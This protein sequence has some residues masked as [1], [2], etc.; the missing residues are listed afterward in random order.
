[1]TRK[2]YELI[3]RVIDSIRG[4]NNDADQIADSITYRFIGAL[5]ADNPRFNEDIFLEASGYNRTKTN[6]Y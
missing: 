3:A 2:D 4:V 5:K 1:M 6:Y